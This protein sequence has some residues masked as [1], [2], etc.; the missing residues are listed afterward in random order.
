M[1]SLHLEREN[2]G[3]PP[4]QKDKF[5]KTIYDISHIVTEGFIRELKLGL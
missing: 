5:T 3:A 4:Q 2:E 1:N